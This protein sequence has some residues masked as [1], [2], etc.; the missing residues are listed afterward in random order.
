[1]KISQDLSKW[2]QWISE[3]VAGRLQ[4]K[5]LNLDATERVMKRWQR[6]QGSAVRGIASDQDWSNFHQTRMMKRSPS[7]VVSRL[8]IDSLSEPIVGWCRCAAEQP[9]NLSC[10]PGHT[11]G[12]RTSDPVRSALGSH[13]I[14]WCDKQCAKIGWA[15]IKQSDRVVSFRAL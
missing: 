1:M 12:D 5:D 14:T 10:H 9:M 11:L 3:G 7:W 6:D 8:S 4:K 13:L 2:R 15:K